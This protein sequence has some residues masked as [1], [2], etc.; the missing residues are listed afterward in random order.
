MKNKKKISASEQRTLWGSRVVIWITMIVVLFPV[1]WIVMSSFSAGDSFFLSSLFP[2]KFSIEHY[3]ELF[4]ETDFGIW[5]FNSLKFCFIVAIIQ[6]VLIYKFGLVDNSF[7]LILVLAGGSAYNIWLLKSYIDGLPVELD[8]AAMVDGAN[9]FQ[10]FYKIII[11]LAMPQLAV[12][13][14][15]SF[16][17]TYSEY[18]ITSIFLQTPGK[19]TLALGLQSFISDQFAA[20]WTLFAAAAVISSLPIMIIFMCLQRFI[21]NGL[22]AGGVKG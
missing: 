9:E 12:I 8:E 15:F 17:A 22:V 1:I 3:V 10:V 11:P 4:R 18:V 21:Q 5:V 20:H 7:A 14:L 16:I 2:E 19:M 6:L 13:F